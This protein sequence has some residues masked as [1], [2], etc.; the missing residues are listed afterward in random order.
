M[1]DAKYRIIRVKGKKTT[2]LYEDYSYWDKER[3]YS[4]HKRKCI[5][6]IGDDGEEVYNNYYLSKNGA[7]GRREDSAPATRKTTVSTT[8]MV[9]QGMVFGLAERRSGVR[10]PLEEVFGAQ[11][12]DRILALARYAIAQGKSLSRAE[13]WLES[14]GDGGLGLTSQRVSE[15]LAAIGPDRVNAFLGSWLGRCRK[16]EGCLFD[17]TSI[18]TY[19]KRNTYAEW[20]YNRDRESLEQVNLALLTSAASGLPLWYSVLPGSM[21]DRSVMGFVLG[22]LGKMGLGGFVFYGDRGFY[23]ET[24]IGLL[25]KSGVR[26]VIPVPSTV[27][28]Q[29]ELIAEYRDR[30]VSPANLIECGDGSVLYGM[31]VARKDAFGRHWCHIYFDPARKDKVVA[32][33]M[34]SLRLR[35]DELAEGKPLDRYKSLYDKYFVVKGGKKR[36]RTVAYNDAA[37]REYLENDSC[38]WVLRTD[39]KGGAGAV[40]SGYRERNAVELN[41][42]DLKNTT[43][44]SRM[45]NHNDRTIAGKIFVMFVALVLKCQLRKDVGKIPAKERKY[46]SE[47]EILDKVDSYTRV[48]FSGR[49][50]DVYSTPTSAQRRIFDLLGLPYTYQGK[51]H[52][53]NAAPKYS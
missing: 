33:F 27:G 6:K 46:W 47:Q 13:D 12:A 37:I 29:K 22:T 7:A 24:N 38:F 23:S 40:L 45:R 25:K 34:R 18:S 11:T 8:V 48:H 36:G 49:Y 2:Y 53:I 43:D 14:H 15:L 31:T 52:N 4:T 16:G 42:D 21:S 30:L 50:K 32:D 10:R 44:L 26:Y 51:K 28:W 39:S 35:R 20:G 9:G 5:G 1:E 41:F 17:I 3:G 19:G